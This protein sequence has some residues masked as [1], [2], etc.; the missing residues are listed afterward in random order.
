MAETAG[1]LEH[2]LTTATRAGF[3]GRLLDRGLARGLI[4]N[5]G[6]L[7]AGSPTFIPTLTEDL[8][9]Y[10]HTIIAMAVRLRGLDPN[11]AILERA[12]LVAAE[13]IEAAIHRG[14]G[15]QHA[16]FHRV[17]A[18]V[19]F[20]LARYSAR[21][22]SILPIEIEEN[23]LAPT[24]RALVQL[25]R[26]QLDAMH[27]LVAS[28]LLDDQHTDDAIASRIE[29]DAEFDESDAIHSML[30]TAFMKGL[31][32]F[33]HAIV[34]GSNDSANAARAQ[35]LGTA[36]EASA[37]NSVSHWWTATLAAQ[38]V[39]ELWRLSLHQRIAP[40]HPTDDD[41]ASW[42]TFRRSY[43]QRLRARQRAAIELWPSQLTAA[44]R[45][46]DLADDL[47]VALPTSAGKTRI[48]ELCILRTLA[49]DRRVVYVTPLR[50]LSAQIERDLGEVFRPLG[51]SVSTL[52]GSAGV[53]MEDAEALRT[54]QIVVSTPE[55]LDFA[56][57]NDSSIIDTVGLVVLDEGHMLGPN[58]REVR[59]EALVQRLL[60]RGDATDRRIVCLSALFPTPAEMQDL[61]AWL[62][63][64][65]PGDPIH[66]TW[67]PTRQRF[68]VLRWTGDAAR[69]DIKVEQESPYVERFVEAYAP[70]ADSRRSRAFPATKNELTLAAAWQFVAQ[71]KEVL[72]YCAI[73]AS[74]ETLGKEILKALKHKVLTPLRE[75]N[76]RI[77]D[78][79]ATGIEWLGAD[80]P[81]VQCLRYGVALHHGG[82][83]RQYLAEV[84]RLMRSGD[85]PLVIASPTL[86]QGLNLSA[87]V[88]LVPSIWR[89]A[90]IIPPAEFANVAGRAGRAF[91]DVEGLV[92]HVVWEKPAYSVKNWEELVS[93][94]KAPL[95]T[96]GILELTLRL[97][98][99]LAAVAGVEI[100]ELIDHVTGQDSAWDFTEIESDPQVTAADWDR[101]VASLDSAVLA[102][103][104]ADAET[105][106]L[107]D[108]LDVVLEKSLFARQLEQHEEA[109]Q[110][111][112]RR[113]VA[114]RAS[115]IWRRTNVSQRKGYHAAGV[116]FSAGQFLD[117]NLS[118]LVKSL[119]LIEA[120][121]TANVPDVVA[122]A[123]LEFAER[124]LHVAPFRPPKGLPDKW[125]EALNAWMRG[126]ASAKV[127]G[128]CGDEGVD[129]LQEA[130]TYRLPWAMEA[131]RV[132]A[133]A[134]GVSDATELTGVAA[135]AAE[136]GT[137]NRSVTVLLRAG[138]NSREAAIAAVESTGGTFDDRPKMLA[139]LSD[140]DVREMS[141]LQNWPTAS[142]RH[143]WLKFLAEENSG[144]R[145]EWSWD[146]EGVKVSWTDA[147]PKSGTPLIIEP[148]VGPQSALVLSPNFERLGTF[149]GSLK[150]HRRQIVRVTAGSNASSTV[151]IE[152]FGPF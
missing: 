31:A 36:S 144:E 71:G 76:E 56:L 61:T 62:R 54:S 2:R 151:D 4:W 130:F 150:R 115:S 7:P 11:A 49:A 40:L 28:W 80:H 44:Q 94:A 116:G 114:A 27:Q 97:F 106:D 121:V 132:H 73:R 84:E 137:P 48:A 60:R 118:E 101:D 1:A 107:A 135:L 19:A 141:A 66:S 32:L 74:V 23:N 148:S 46:L 50:A 18:A 41:A 59:Y 64:D 140:E 25:L 53:E 90:E 51:V 142:S 16:G 72:V 21:A 65:D 39:D 93:K 136:S 95:I 83:P 82:L 139:W 29:T 67:R 149:K 134:M 88:L 78:A 138:L 24:E 5:S 96:S 33:D 110:T 87:S 91:V 6:K 68:G 120:S 38:L 98:R 13:A 119:L 30:T 99:R 14:E 108:A 113:F 124:V 79:I 147:A 133:L 131:V 70:P 12:F 63:Q 128:A 26:R 105:D 55:K 52:Y 122:G 104:D 126:E 77:E 152:Y 86:A 129:V 45:S 57:R 42:A 89:K 146:S 3:R 123:T 58:E 111:L 109:S 35:L 92:V 125:K 69:L 117:A 75:N 47:V 34:T 100:A 102:L 15:G 145:R 143:A 37:L 8:L 9:D 127:I 85:C 22:Y 112:I 10:A 81:A 43:I 17:S 103:L 20:H